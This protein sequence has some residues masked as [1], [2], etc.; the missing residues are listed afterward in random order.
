MQV[1][2]SAQCRCR[3]LHFYVVKHVVS[4]VRRGLLVY[5]DEH[6]FEVRQ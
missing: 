6:T 2:Q 4:S 1:Q 5:P 3:E